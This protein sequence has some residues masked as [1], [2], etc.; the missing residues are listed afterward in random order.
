[1]VIIND[2]CVSCLTMKADRQNLR[3]TRKSLLA[4]GVALTAYGDKRNL[5]LTT[6]SPRV[7]LCSDDTLMTHLVFAICALV[8]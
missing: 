1:M 8:A 4:I 3:A 5:H 7:Q 2:V 6:N